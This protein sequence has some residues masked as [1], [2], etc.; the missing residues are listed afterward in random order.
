MGAA[1]EAKQGV[2]T[3]FYD[4]LP[5]N[6]NIT[7]KNYIDPAGLVALHNVPE[8]PDPLP[9]PLEAFGLL[10]FFGRSTK[11]HCRP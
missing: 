4:P 1:G 5:T 6:N 2:S 8:V 10:F 7:E 9:S 3:G 11:V